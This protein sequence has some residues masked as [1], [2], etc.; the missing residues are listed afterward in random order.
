[1]IKYNYTEKVFF[2]EVRII[3]KRPAIAVCVTGYDWEYETRVVSGV[4]ERCKELGCHLL[5][6]SDLMR[7]PELNSGRT[8]PPEILHGEIEIYNLINYY[9]LA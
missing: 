2:R 3:M 5:V 1:M 4:Y 7:K 9:H 8:L 6:F